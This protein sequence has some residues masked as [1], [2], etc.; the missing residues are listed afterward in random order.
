M[1]EQKLYRTLEAAALAGITSEE[2]K[3]TRYR[4]M[5]IAKRLSLSPICEKTREGKGGKPEK[6]WN[7]EQIAAIKEETIAIISVFSAA[8]NIAW[9]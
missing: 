5:E 9:F 6:Y 4:F 8:C 3:N 1:E 2:P 7:M